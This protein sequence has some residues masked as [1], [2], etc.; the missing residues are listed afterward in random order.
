MM[1]AV[2]AVTTAE[3][4]RNRMPFS[5]L[6]F[7]QTLA[8]RPAVWLSTPDIYQLPSDPGSSKTPFHYPGRGGKSSGRLQIQDDA[9][10]VCF[11][12]PGCESSAVRATGTG[13][14]RAA[15]PDMLALACFSL[16]WIRSITA[17]D[18]HAWNQ[19][20][21]SDG[22]LNY[23]LLTTPFTSKKSD[24]STKHTSVTCQ[25]EVMP[26]VALI[27]LLFQY[28]CH[29]RWISWLFSWLIELFGL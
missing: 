2:V 4:L 21:S 7:F 14:R 25:M 23:T 13:A 27:R 26:K 22:W 24:C 6:R 10:A 18:V 19:L 9:P 3:R 17:L 16:L 8:A 29:C 28:Y 5:L 15:W 1:P 12:H 20:I 11:I